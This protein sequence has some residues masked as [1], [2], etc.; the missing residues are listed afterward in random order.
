MTTPLGG[1]LLVVVGVFAGFLNTVGGGGSMLTL[2]VLMLL[3]LPADLANGTVRPSVIGHAGLGI[4]LF[5]RE[6]KLEIG[7]IGPIVAPTMIG[8]LLGALAASQAPPRIL[9]PILIVAMLTV[10]AL[11]VIRPNALA[12]KGE[13]PLSPRD[14]PIAG[15]LALLAAGFYGG[16]V[17][18]GV[19]LVLLLVI[20]GVLRHDLVRASALKLVCAL[21]FGV[22]ALGVYIWA[23]Q[24]VWLPA[25]ALALGTMIG[26]AFGVRFAVRVRQDVLRW[27][28]FV[29]V[30]AISIGALLRL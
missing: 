15:F 18:A 16:F 12:P 6:G 9:G 20:A 23:D 27:V 8:G 24:V 22:V 19:G 30:V 7:H 4:F 2:P 10:A 17:Q 3:G 26:A 1:V 25:L 11:M 13:P 29:C 14:R 21:M 5:H 28:V